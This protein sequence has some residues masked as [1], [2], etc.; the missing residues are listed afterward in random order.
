MPPKRKSRIVEEVT[1][2]TSAPAKR[3]RKAKKEKEEVKKTRF[4][5]LKKEMDEDDATL[6][7][8]T[9]GR[10][11][12]QM[13]DTRIASVKSPWLANVNVGD[14]HTVPISHGEGRFVAPKAV[15]EECKGRVDLV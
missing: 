8:N 5:T 2:Q 10:H 13:V 9:I 15:L 3:G 7:F 6:T 4:S 1:L 14:I 11:L 12:S